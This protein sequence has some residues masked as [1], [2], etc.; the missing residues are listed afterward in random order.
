MKQR[1][2]I[3]CKSPTVMGRMTSTTRG[4]S[5]IVGE[6]EEQEEEY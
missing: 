6:E 3:H 1:F 2:E 5:Q 4:A